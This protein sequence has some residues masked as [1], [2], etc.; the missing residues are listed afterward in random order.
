MGARGWSEADFHR[1]ADMDISATEDDD[2][3]LI[4]RLRDYWLHGKWHNQPIRS[5]GTWASPPV[6]MPAKTAHLCEIGHRWYADARSA[7]FRMVS[8]MLART[9]KP[10]ILILNC[11]A[12]NHRRARQP[13]DRAAVDR[14]GDAGRDAASG[15]GGCPPCLR[16]PRRAVQDAAAPCMGRSAGAHR[17]QH[18]AL[19]RMKQVTAQARTLNP[20]LLSSPWAGRWRGCRRGCRAAISTT[21]ATAMSEQITAVV[22]TVFGGSTCRAELPTAALRPGARSAPD[23]LCRTSSTKLS[24][25]LRH[26]RPEDRTRF[27]V[28]TSDRM[29]GAS[30]RTALHRHVRVSCQNFFRRTA[31]PTSERAAGVATN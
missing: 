28:P 24:V 13:A 3:A 22:D 16:V 27:Q 11:H 1:I 23:R 31:A 29:S 19:D 14:R 20:A 26:E 15:N 8:L 7:W 12:D 4:K 9:R 10:R 6:S 30:D 17:S 5:C 2:V 25:Q 18:T 21:C